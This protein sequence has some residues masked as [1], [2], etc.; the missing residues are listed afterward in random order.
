MKITLRQTVGKGRT[1]EKGPLDS[2]EYEVISLSLIVGYHTKTVIKVNNS[3]IRVVVVLNHLYD[4]PWQSKFKKVCYKEV[5]RLFPVNSYNTLSLT[6]KCFFSQKKS[7][8]NILSPFLQPVDSA[9]VT[10]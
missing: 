7:R 3:D 9:G 6:S 8:N 5:M 2:T 1:V 4:E 10:K